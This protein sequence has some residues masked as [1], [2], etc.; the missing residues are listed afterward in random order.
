MD[1]QDESSAKAERD[2]AT[3]NNVMEWRSYVLGVLSGVAASAATAAAQAWFESPSI[4]AVFLL[5]IMGLGLASFT[6]DQCVLLLHK[7]RRYIVAVVWLLAVLGTGARVIGVGELSMLPLLSGLASRSYL[8]A[9]APPWVAACIPFVGAAVLAG[10]TWRFKTPD[11]MTVR[12][13]M[14]LFVR[15]VADGSSESDAVRLTANALS[16]RS[17]IVRRVVARSIEA[18]PSEQGTVDRSETEG[19]FGKQRSAAR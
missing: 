7:T 6:F 13:I 9:T 17:Y 14:R 12:E 5:G 1:V 15:H 4:Q 18:L 16:M 3:E 19:R 2:R 8:W 11:V 10:T